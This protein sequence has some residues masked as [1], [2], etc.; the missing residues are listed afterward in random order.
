MKTFFIFLLFTSWARAFTLNN[1]F[2]ASFSKTKVT[3]TVAGNSTCSNVGMTVYE[4]QDMIEP[5]I[6][7]FWNRVPT[8]SLR[9]R[10]GGFS[11]VINNITTGR[12]C[13]PTDDTC[14]SSASGILIPPV[15]DIIISCNNKAENFGGLNVL[16]VTIPN[17]FS[18]KNIKG[19]VIL[20]N[21]QA[22]SAF[23]SLSHQDKMSVIAHEIGHAIGLG[24]S[25]D[26]AALMYYK[27]VNLRKNLGQD[28]VDGVS[29]LY[30]VKLDGCG[31]FGNTID[32]N[33]KSDPSMWQ[34]GISLAL[35]ILMAEMMKLFNR[36]KA[37]PAT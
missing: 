22:G 18:G 33:N 10:T 1:N 34:L 37:R 31:L 7:D 27:V 30:P 2:G 11:G 16:A 36:S 15:D 26:K 23:A 21:D 12:L 24:H 5:A 14:I 25:E 13:A 8:S 20:I 3:I 28:D 19:S 32:T 29:Y 17:K 4:L 6:H 35:L 9:L